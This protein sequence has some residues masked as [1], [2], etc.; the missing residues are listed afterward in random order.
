MCRR[1]KPLERRPVYADSRPELDVAH[2]FAP[3]FK[4]PHWI[5]QLGAL[6]EANAD[7]ALVDRDVGECS[8]LNAS[9][10]AAVMHELA[11]IGAAT[12]QQR[13]RLTHHRTEL[14]KLCA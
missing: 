9:R 11:N 10:R 3:A 5:R 1:D 14:A 7:M 4:H 6:E 13:E 2:E 8:V 12:A